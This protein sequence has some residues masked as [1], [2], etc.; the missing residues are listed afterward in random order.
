[1]IRV[2]QRL[3]ICDQLCG[4]VIR[5]WGTESLLS[6]ELLTAVLMISTACC[7]ISS[8][9]IACFAAVCWCWFCGAEMQEHFG[10]SSHVGCMLKS[11]KHCCATVNLQAALMRRQCRLM[12]RMVVSNE[13]LLLRY[14]LCW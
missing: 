11:C 7:L 1:M 2:N 9:D 13:G 8:I 4:V 3:L 14:A 6:I 5:C 10:V 12:S